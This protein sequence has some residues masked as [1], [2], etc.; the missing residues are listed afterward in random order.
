[1][2]QTP[3]GSSPTS[4]DNAISQL[5]GNFQKHINEKNI[6]M[7]KCDEL[8]TKMNHSHDKRLTAAS[9]ITDES[10]RE[11]YCNLVNLNRQLLDTVMHLSS[12]DDSGKLWFTTLI[13]ASKNVV[14]CNQTSKNGDKTPELTQVS[15]FIHEMQLQWMQ[16]YLSLGSKSVTK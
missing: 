5:Q 16:E 10:K 8:V 9:K 1:M 7:K 14:F 11:M 6:H 13:D 4:S 3:L 15:N 12:T 2:A